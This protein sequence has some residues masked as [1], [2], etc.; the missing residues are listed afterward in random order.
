[1]SDA[2]KVIYDELLP[3]N[4]NNIFVKSNILLFDLDG[5]LI[6]TNLANFLAYKEACYKILGIHLSFS[7]RRFNLIFLE[8]ILKSEKL[9]IK[10]EILVKIKSLKDEIYNNFMDQTVVNKN[11]KQIIIDFYKTNRIFLIT[12][13]NRNRVFQLLK[14]HSLNSYFFEIFINSS[15]NKYQN[16]IKI[17]NLNPKDL[18]VFENEEKEIHNALDVGIPFKNIIKVEM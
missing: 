11:L 7:P 2:S 15:L 13:A 10:Y 8:H 5:T 17:Y 4:L 12:N 6:D 14:Y 1:M 16:I 3:I 9:D 18:V